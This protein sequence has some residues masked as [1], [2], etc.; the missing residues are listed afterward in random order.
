MST[1]PRQLHALVVIGKACRS[2]SEL[3]DEMPSLWV[4]QMGPSWWRIGTFPNFSVLVGCTA[5]TIACLPG[6][7]WTCSTVTFCCPLPRYRWRAST[8]VKVR[9]LFAA[10]CVATFVPRACP[11]FHPAPQYRSRQQGTI[12]VLASRGA[13]RTP[14]RGSV[15]NRT[16]HKIGKVGFE[17]PE[18]GYEPQCLSRVDVILE[19]FAATRLSDPR[20]LPLA[21]V[22]SSARGQRPEFYPRSPPRSR[23]CLGSHRIDRPNHDR[24]VLGH[25]LEAGLISRG[26]ISRRQLPDQHLAGF[27]G[28]AAPS[29]PCASAPLDHCRLSGQR[30]QPIAIQ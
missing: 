28:L 1:N 12:D 17:C 29:L 19:G 14:I 21:A 24:M 3:R 6:W 27:S 25:E 9:A 30:N 22:P 16:E 2:G 7:T 4:I 15:D 26:T 20:W 5:P 11:R 23:Y 18:D 13:A 8:I 10:R